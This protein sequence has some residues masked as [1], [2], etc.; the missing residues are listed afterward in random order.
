MPAIPGSGRSRSLILTAMI[1]AVSMTFIDMTII[2]IA[3]PPIQRDLGLS[4]T[5]VQWTVNG[6]LLTLAALFAFGGRLADRF[7]HR[8]M[9]TLGVIVFAAAS[10][11]CGLTPRGDIADG[12]LVTFRAVQGAGG[13]TSPTP[14]RPYSWSWRASWPPPRSSPSPGCGPDDRKSRARPELYPARRRRAKRPGPGRDQ[15]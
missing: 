8:R 12:W 10:G 9:V 1:F 4:T 6:Y 11:L 5:G 3:V 14:R 15:R 2:S 13:A 7:G